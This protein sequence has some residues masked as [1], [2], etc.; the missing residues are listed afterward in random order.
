[1]LCHRANCGSRNVSIHT[2]YKNLLIARSGH[3]EPRVAAA[4]P[5]GPG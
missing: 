5:Y 2:S 3:A 4:L 1:M